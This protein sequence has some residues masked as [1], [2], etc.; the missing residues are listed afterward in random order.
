MHDRAG[1][2]ERVCHYMHAARP[3]DTRVA[4]KY[5]N[6]RVCS[7][8]RLNYKPNVMPASRRPSDPS[9]SQPGLDLHDNTARVLLLRLRVKHLTLRTQPVTLGDQ[10]INL[11]TPLQHALNR[12]MQHNLGLVKLLLDLDDAVGLRRVLVLRDVCLEL[13]EAKLGLALLEGG[14]CGARVL[15]H[16]LVDDFGEDAVRDESG[17][18]V[19]GYYDA[20]DAFCA[21]VGVECVLFPKVS[22]C[23]F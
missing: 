16:K 4:Y 12:L 7:L 1:Q 15:C 21:A 5:E 23:A 22:C 2:I 3:I 9:M 13:G 17:V 18:L 6:Q 20:A 19:V 8:H 10:I 14:V 11:L